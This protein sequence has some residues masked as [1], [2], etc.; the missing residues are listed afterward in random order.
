MKARVL[1]CVAFS[2]ICL[3]TA[4][5][6]ASTSDTN[7]SGR[8][9][10]A[11][12]E[13]KGIFPTPFD[14][15]EFYQITKDSFLKKVKSS[16]ANRFSPAEV[17]MMEKFAVNPESTTQPEMFF[18]TMFEL[19]ESGRYEQKLHGIKSLAKVSRPAPKGLNNVDLKDFYEMVKMDYFKRV[20][21]RP[22]PPMDARESGFFERARVNAKETNAAPEDILLL[23]SDLFDKIEGIK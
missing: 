21:K 3:F 14:L 23:A 15:E 20:S 9:Q 11:Q 6:P 17:K 12:Q 13:Q 19:L 7:S 8:G 5:K 18:Q 16:A 10:A 1:Y 2:S 4:C 22:A